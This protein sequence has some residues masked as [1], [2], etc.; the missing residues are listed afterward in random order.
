MDTLLL[1]FHP[2]FHTQFTPALNQ[3]SAQA[4]WIGSTLQSA[5]WAPGTMGKPRPDEPV[6]AYI[7]AMAAG[8]IVICSLQPGLNLS[9]DVS[10]LSQCDGTWNTCHTRDL[11]AAWWHFQGQR[12]AVLGVG[13]GVLPMFLADRFPALEV[14]A[15]ELDAAVVAAAV[16]CMGMAGSMPAAGEGELPGSLHRKG[17]GISIEVADALMW[18]LNRSSEAG[19]PP[20]PHLPGH[21][22]GPL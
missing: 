8:A 12:V 2:A 7:R 21:L 3:T 6:F 16:E 5:I 17:P 11:K 1:T 4:L 15:V 19:G 9:K 14:D 22:Q 10:Q 18:A 13:G 20:Q